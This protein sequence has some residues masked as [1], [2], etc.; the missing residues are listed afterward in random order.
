[1]RQE[2]GRQ[3][4]AAPDDPSLHASLGLALAHLGRKDEA[5]RE[6]E[7]AVAL[8]PVDKDALYGPV[9]LENLMWIHVHLGNDDEAL[10]I[11]ERVLEAPG[12]PPAAGRESTPTP[13]RS[14]RTPASRS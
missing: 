11:L 8:A 5:V 7:R 12:P 2:L 14:T 3:L 4:E 1:M 13:S 10:D 6:G 9:F